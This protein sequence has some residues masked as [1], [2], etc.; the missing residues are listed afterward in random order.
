MHQLVSFSILF[1]SNCFSVSYFRSFAVGTSLSLSL[2][3]FVKDCTYLFKRDTEGE[4]D[5]GRGR[6]RLSVGN[7]MWDSI[8]GLWDHALS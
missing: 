4:G 3:L 1:C 6:S 8:L 2:S 7:P 5:I